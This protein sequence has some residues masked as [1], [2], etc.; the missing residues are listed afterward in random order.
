MAILTFILGYI[1]GGV[2]IGA[3]FVAHGAD[4]IDDLLEINAKSLELAS[5]YAN[6]IIR[7]RN[8][9]ASFESYIPEDDKDEIIQM[10]TF[11]EY[12]EDKDEN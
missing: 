1:L 10:L 4:D 12:Q 8:R 5:K 2:I 6:T 7:A 3:C 9:I 11:A